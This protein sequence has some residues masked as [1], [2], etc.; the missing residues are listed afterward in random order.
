MPKINEKMQPKTKTQYR[1]WQIEPT[2]DYGF[3]QC[4]YCGN[5]GD[6][7]GDESN[8]DNTTS[9]WFSC[10]DCGIRYT[11]ETVIAHRFAGI[12]TDD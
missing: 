5:G 12:E 1:S 3:G 10:E 8:G 7:E 11:Y 6:H 2:H 9:E 4:P